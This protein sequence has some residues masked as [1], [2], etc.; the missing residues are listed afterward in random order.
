MIPMIRALSHLGSSG[1]DIEA[2]SGTVTCAA[3]RAS[4]ALAFAGRRVECARRR[5]RLEYHVKAGHTQRVGFMLDRGGAEPRRWDAPPSPRGLPPLWTWAL[6][7]PPR[8]QQ[9]DYPVWPAPA[10]HAAARALLC[11]WAGAEP[12]LFGGRNEDFGPRIRGP[13]A[14]WRAE[15]PGA[16]V[17][18]VDYRSDLVDADFAHLAGIRALSME[19]CSMSSALTS[20][21]F[22]HLRGA[23]TLRMAYC[24]Q[25]TLT[26]SAFVHLRGVHTLDMR[27]CTQPTI[28]GATLS[29]LRGV[30][31]L[32]IYGCV[33]AVIAAARALR[34]PV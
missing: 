15:R 18:N 19:G 7:E 17:A 4:E 33:P 29:H 31:I 10:G 27:G 25:A 11:H 22:A 12:F 26:D 14:A 5:S 13:L 30:R 8:E 6:F 16:L 28:T 24:T 23:H 34:L 1:Y 21:A 3:A 2:D 9:R 32:Y 20:A